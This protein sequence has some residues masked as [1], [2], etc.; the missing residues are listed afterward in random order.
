MQTIKLDEAVR[1]IYQIVDQRRNR[2]LVSPFFFIVGAGVSHPPIPLAREI[3]E[4]CRKEAEKYG[5]VAS[6]V[7]GKAID[8]YSHWLDKAY[9]SPDELQEYLR[10]LMKNLPISKANLR[11]AHLVLDGTIARS[12]FTPNFDDMLTKAL[13]LFGKR[14]LVCDHPLTVGRMKIDS[15]DIQIIHVH[16]SYWFYDCCNLTQDITDRSGSAPMSNKLGE[17]FSDHSPLVIGYSG[18]EGDILMASLKRR[19]ESDMGKL[20]IPLYW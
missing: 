16:G 19:L 20:K 13:E 12:V 7:S 4:L 18:W 17:F 3:E 15:K 9:P 1:Q 6:P 5:Q 11:L 2:K 8:S 14:P 10:G